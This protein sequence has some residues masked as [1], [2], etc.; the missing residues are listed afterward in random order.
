MCPVTEKTLELRS[1]VAQL[2]YLN[3]CLLFAY[4]M[5]SDVAHEKT[6]VAS[7]QERVRKAFQRQQPGG[8]IRRMCLCLPDGQLSLYYCWRPKGSD[9][10]FFYSDTCLLMGVW[11]GLADVF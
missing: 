6:K 8:K 11:F 9:S 1:V 10:P 7:S 2:V 4:E 3:F 5:Q